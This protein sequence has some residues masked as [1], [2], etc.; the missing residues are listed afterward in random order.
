MEKLLTEKLSL[1]NKEIEKELKEIYK[2]MDSWKGAKGPFDPKSVRRRELIA[3]KQQVLYRM[4]DSK[5]L[6]DK[7]EAYFNFIIY[8]IINGYLEC[9]KNKKKYDF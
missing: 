1:T 8:K 5:L 7:K 3:V 6:R 9:L 4:E 2:E